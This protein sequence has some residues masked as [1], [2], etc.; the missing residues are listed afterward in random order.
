MVGKRWATR[1][2]R[3][4]ESEAKPASFIDLLRRCLFRFQRLRASAAASARFL[5]NQP[6]AW[7]ARRTAA[8]PRWAAL[9]LRRLFLA[10]RPLR[11]LPD[12]ALV[13]FFMSANGR[14]DSVDIEV[15][16]SADSFP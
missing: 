9:S 3:S 14:G 10:C 12:P 7:R 16:G 8:S 11:S 6:I 4:A 15:V 5:L 2:D 13:F 1:Q